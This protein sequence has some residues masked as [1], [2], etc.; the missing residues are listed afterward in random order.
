MTI[1]SC[2]NCGVMLDSDRLPQ[3]SIGETHRTSVTC[4]VCDHQIDAADGEE[5]A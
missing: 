2:E 1:I 3:E 5:V 4:P